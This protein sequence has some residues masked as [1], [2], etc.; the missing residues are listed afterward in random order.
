MHPGNKRT[1]PAKA[2]TSDPPRKPLKLEEMMNDV[3]QTI[4]NVSQAYKVLRERDLTAMENYEDYNFKE[5]IQSL[6]QL[7]YLHPSDTHTIMNGIR[8]VAHCLLHNADK[9][10]VTLAEIPAQDQNTAAQAHMELLSTIEH[11]TAMAKLGTETAQKILGDAKQ[12]SESLDSQ[13]KRLNDMASKWAADIGAKLEKTAEDLI[14]KLEDTA[15]SAC[16]KVQTASKIFQEATSDFQNASTRRTYSQVLQSNT[17]LKPADYSQPRNA[18]PSDVDNMWKDL[19]DKAK[20]AILNRQILIDP[21]SRHVTNGSGLMAE[22]SIENI[23]EKANKVLKVMA[24]EGEI[25]NNTLMCFVGVKKLSNGGIL[26][27]MNN[28]A[29]ADTVRRKEVRK[30]FIE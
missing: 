24:N 16:E 11:A 21:K 7:T 13:S 10:K 12:I 8:S 14:G 26:L 9:P 17:P 23:K 25:P 30:I 5:I 29:A 19:R 18:P 20:C 4:R 1:V 3:R 6:F 22:T 15:T 2:T 28:E 27:K